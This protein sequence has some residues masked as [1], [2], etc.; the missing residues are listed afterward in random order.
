MKQDLE[1]WHATQRRGALAYREKLRNRPRKP[2]APMSKKR[3]RE[4]PER[5]RILAEVVHGQPCAVRWDENCRGMA[6]DG[7]EIVPR[8]RRPGSHLERELVVPVCRP[9][10]T[11]LTEHPAEANRRGFLFH[12]WEVPK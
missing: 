2:I 12:S 7:H 8:G 3:R 10:H 9:C 4:A 1:R 6:T 5:R 11:A